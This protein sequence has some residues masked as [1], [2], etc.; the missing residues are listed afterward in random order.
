[1]VDAAWSDTPNRCRVLDEIVAGERFHQKHRTV[2]FQGLPGVLGG[3]NR[4]THVVQAIEEADQIKVPL[5]VPVRGRGD[6]ADAIADPG[7]GG[8]LAR[9]LDR[10][11]GSR[12]PRIES[13][14]RPSP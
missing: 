13:V 2:V 7:V 10:W 12:S 3:P 5:G 4:I 8:A 1:M 14:D 9:G 11:H 6:E